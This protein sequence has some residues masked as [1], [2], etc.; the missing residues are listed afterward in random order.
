MINT[1]SDT[2]TKDTNFA[3][4]VLETQAFGPVC[5]CYAVD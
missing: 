3:N 4:I 2:P 5:Y 1:K